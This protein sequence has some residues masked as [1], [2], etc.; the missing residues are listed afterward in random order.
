[1]SRMLQYGAS[2]RGKKT[3]IYLNYEY[4]R[5][6]ENKRGQTHWRCCTHERFHCKSRLLTDSDG[7]VGNR[8][9]DHTHSGN[10]ATALSRK[11]VD[12]MKKKM[13]ETVA[14]PSASQGAVAAEL[15]DHVLMALPKRDTLTRALRR[16]RC[17]AVS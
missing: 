14:T 7:V 17:K 11:A 3:L 8:Q 4:W 13:L 10:V 2:K 12:E 16:H 5:E 6:R 9:P 15:P 1:M